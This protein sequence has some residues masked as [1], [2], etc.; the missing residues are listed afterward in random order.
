[1]SAYQADENYQGSTTKSMPN[2]PIKT[3]GLGASP[4]SYYECLD[5]ANTTGM[6]IMQRPKKAC[7]RIKWSKRSQKPNPRRRCFFRQT[8]TLIFFASTQSHEPYKIFS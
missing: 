8:K 4:P 5:P 6:K 2:T 1:M 3:E 7:L